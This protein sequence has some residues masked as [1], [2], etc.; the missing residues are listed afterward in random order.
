VV[1]QSE[2]AYLAEFDEDDEEEATL[3]QLTNK[4]KTLS[5]SM[6]VVN[7]TSKQHHTF[8]LTARVGGIL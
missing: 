4:D 7:A 3:S 1:D 6:H 5:I 8:T 2:L